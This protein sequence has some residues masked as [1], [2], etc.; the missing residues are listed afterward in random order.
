[1]FRQNP[2]NYTNC[3]C[4]LMFIFVFSEKILEICISHRCVYPCASSI[5]SS[6]E[7]I[8]SGRSESGQIFVTAYRTVLGIRIWP[9]PNSLD[10]SGSGAGNLPCI[11]FLVYNLKT[12]PSLTLLIKT[13]FLAVS[14]SGIFSRRIF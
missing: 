2:T 13:I 14:K 11:N 5:V 1:M 12:L 9:D 6:A 3:Y 8:F 7:I 4:T 10:G